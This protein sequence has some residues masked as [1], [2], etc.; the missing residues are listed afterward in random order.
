MN[1]RRAQ[2]RANLSPRE[3]PANR[4]KYREFA[5][6]CSRKGTLLSLSCTFCW[7]S[8][9]SAVNRNRELTGAYQACIRE[10]NPLIRIRCKRNVSGSRF[11][12]GGT[13][14]GRVCLPA[15]TN[16]RIVAG[17][18]SSET[19]PN[20]SAS[21]FL[22]SEELFDDSLFEFVR[23]GNSSRTI[24]C[25]LPRA[26]C[27]SSADHLASQSIIDLSGVPKASCFCPIQ[28]L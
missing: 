3:F 18:F 12:S 27:N 5:K 9:P 19:P 17:V 1:W 22:D 13:Q 7:R 16:I 6:F 11:E 23:K 26:I 28:C 24:A 14:S 10:F 8:P 20:A 15:A 25:T 2:S 21:D 4:E